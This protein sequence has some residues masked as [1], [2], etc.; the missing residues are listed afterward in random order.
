MNDVTE[1]YFDLHVTGLGY[2]NR[3]REIKVNRGQDFLA[4]DIAALHGAV[5]DVNYTRFVCPVSGREAERVI[6]CCMVKMAAD[7]DA[8]VLVGF[9]LG[10]LSPELFTYRSGDKAGETGISLKAR[11]LKIGWV[12]VN[13]DTVYTA[14]LPEDKAQEADCDSDEAVPVKPSELAESEL[15]AKQ[16]A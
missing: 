14:P 7:E 8:K 10:D 12:K 15:E 16:T 11:L 6:R 13:G 4:V 5:D 3:P 2:L 1:K 9:R